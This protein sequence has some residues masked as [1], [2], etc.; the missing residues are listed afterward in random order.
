MTA[1]RDALSG[2]LRADGMHVE[3]STYYHVYALDF[4]LHARIL[5]GLNGVDVPD[6]L[7]RTLERMLLVLATLSRMNDCPSVNCRAARTDNSS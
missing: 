3:Q 2:L 7:E 5:A 1:G 4:L 6:S